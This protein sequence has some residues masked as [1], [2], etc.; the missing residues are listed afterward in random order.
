M[1]ILVLKAFVYDLVTTA[2]TGAA[3]Y[4]TVPENVSAMGFGDAIVPII[5]GVAGAAVIAFRRYLIEK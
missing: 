3:L 1:N 4:L 5:V 2:L